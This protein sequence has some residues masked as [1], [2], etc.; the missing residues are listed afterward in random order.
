MRIF[1]IKNDGV[2]K[3]LAYLLYYEKEKLF[4]IELPD[5]ANPWE[6]PLIL[7]SFAKR[8]IKT[9]NSYWSKMWVEQRIVPSD[10]QN[11]GQVL[12]ENNLSE[13]DEFSLLMLAE[14]R[15]AQ[16]DFYLEE[17][18]DIPADIAKRY[19]KKIEDVVPLRNY[20]LLVFFRDGAVKKCDIRNFFKNNKAMETYL[21]LKKGAFDY[22]SVQPGGYGI[23]WE[24]NMTVTDTELYDSGLSV[25]L[26]MSDFKDF[27]EHRVVN[28]S[29]AAELLGCSRQN[30]NDLV[31][32]GK[33]HP[34]KS[35]PKSTLFLK[36]EIMKRNWQ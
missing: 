16:D 27:A 31:K 7:S 9:V 29:E 8:N 12:K 19:E 2:K 22:V 17:I 13:Y 10:R 11:L 36:S 33:L 1:A 14:G 4:Y 32:R 5:D 15:C 28:S 20:W 30:I 35:N 6:T 34:L 24:E 25:P 3:T 18:S 23:C 21:T 26:S